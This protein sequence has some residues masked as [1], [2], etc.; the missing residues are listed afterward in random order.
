MLTVS[1]HTIEETLLNRDSKVLDLGCRYFGWSNAMLEYVD[2]VYCVDADNT[3]ENYELQFDFL[4]AA[5]SFDSG[6]YV[7]FV[8]YG[9]GTGNYLY[10]GGSLP[11]EFELS[12]VFCM[13]LKEVSKHFEVPYWDLIK[14]DIEGSEFDILINLKEPPATQLTFELHQHTAKKKTEEQ[15]Q[16]LFK[17]LEQWYNLVH[18]DYSRKHGLS[19]NYWDVLAVLK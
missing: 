2:K 19:E 9:N 15:V 17:H 18:I 14:F 6:K 4:N 12:N 1:E 10:E 8:K 16:Q 11:S 5:V 13:N 7:S 3:V